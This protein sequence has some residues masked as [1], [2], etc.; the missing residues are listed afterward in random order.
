MISCNTKHKICDNN[1]A[2]TRI[3]VDTGFDWSVRL[4]SE[5]KYLE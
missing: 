5:D 1:H 3:V 4:L 2:F